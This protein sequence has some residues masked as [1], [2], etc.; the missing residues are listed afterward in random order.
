MKTIA[1]PQFPIEGGCL[2]GA[3]RYRITAP[4]PAVYNCHC[5]DC[6]RVSGGT[7]TMSMP[8][9]RDSVELLAG[10]L[11]SYDKPADSGRTVRML[12]CARCGTQIWN[13]P[14]SSPQMLVLKPGT[15]DD[16]RWAVPIGNIWTS[17]ALPW[18]EIDPAGVNFSG[19]PPDRQ[20]L[21]DAWSAATGA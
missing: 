8:I 18:A 20:P 4:P 1:L 7:H 6:Q 14:L 9:A 11:A 2:C 17:S 19:Q 5:R 15:L 10:E 12:G 21:Y 16:P 13:E 3:V